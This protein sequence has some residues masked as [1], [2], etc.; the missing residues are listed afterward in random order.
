MPDYQKGKIYKIWDDNYTKCYIE[1]T[2]ENLSKR[3]TKHRDKYKQYLQKQKFNNTSFRLF[4][5]FGIGSCNIELLE[6]YPCSCKSEEETREGHHIRT[7]ECLNR[8]AMGRSKKEHYRVIMKPYEH[9]GKNTETE[10]KNTNMKWTKS[11][12]KRKRRNYNWTSQGKTTMRMW[13]LHIRYE[14]GIP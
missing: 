3:M 7:E 1:S 10:Q 8:K 13:L 11:L 5:E 2:V 4:E 9:R 12:K 6:L 14:Y